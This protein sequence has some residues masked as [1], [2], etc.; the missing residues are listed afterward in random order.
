MSHNLLVRMLLGIVTA[1]LVGGT[2]ISF[3]CESN[4]PAAVS[5]VTEGL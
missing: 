2:A 4:L 1:A 3:S 5:A